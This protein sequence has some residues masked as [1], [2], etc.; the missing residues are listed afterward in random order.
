MNDVEWLRTCNVFSEHSFGSPCLFVKDFPNVDYLL[1]EFAGVVRRLDNDDKFY[2]PMI[3]YADSTRRQLE[4]MGKALADD[5]LLDDEQMARVTEKVLSNYTSRMFLAGKVEQAVVAALESRLRFQ[6]LPKLKPSEHKDLCNNFADE[7]ERLVRKVDRMSAL[8]IEVGPL[9]N[10]VRLDF[11]DAA[12]HAIEVAR[13][14]ADRPVLK[15]P[16]ADNAERIFVTK[17]T[18]EWFQLNAYGS[19]HEA[20]AS[21]INAVFHD[22]EPISGTEVQVLVR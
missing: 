4:Q 22:W 11:A 2:R 10:G 12:R 7:L 9:I 3:A 16:N 13:E 1:P 20:V 8:G 18:S 17:E 6:R 5:D 21:L 15:R 19:H 14:S